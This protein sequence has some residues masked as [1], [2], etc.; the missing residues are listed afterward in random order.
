[1]NRIKSVE[2][3]FSI[4]VFLTP[5]QCTLWAQSTAPV[6]KRI[7]I[8]SLCAIAFWALLTFPFSVAKA[9]INNELEQIKA[10]DDPEVPAFPGAKGFGAVATGGRGGEVYI[11][12][13]LNNSGAGSFR[14]AVEASGPRTIVFAVSGTIELQSSLILRDGNVTIAGQTAPGDGICIKNY[15]FRLGG[16]DNVII[17]YISSRPGIDK[18]SADDAITGGGSNIIID[19]C[20]FS[21]AMDEVASLYAN[22]MLTMQWCIVSESLWKSKHPQG[23]HGMGGIWGGQSVSFHHNL[24]AHNNNRNPR[25]CGSRYT[26]RADL[27]LVDYRN[28][29]IYNWGNNSAYGG[30]GGK[31]NLVNNYYKFGPGTVSSRKKRIIAP[32]A[33]DGSN[34]QAKGVWG[35]F[36]ISGNFVNGFPDVTEDNWL[37]VEEVPDSIIP[38]IKSLTPFAVKEITM[39]SPEDAY[40]DVIDHAGASFPKRDPVDSRISEETRTGTAT[41]A[42]NSSLP[43]IINDPTDVGS[44][45]LLLSAPAPLDTDKDGMPDEWEDENGLNKNDP[46]D[47]KIIAADGYS[48][49]EHY[50]NGLVTDFK[51]LLRPMNLELTVDDKTVSL[52]WTDLSDNESGFILERSA[53]NGANFTQIAELDANTVSYTDNSIEEYGKYQYRIKAINTEMETSFTDPVI[54]EVS[55]PNPP[56]YTLTINQTGSGIVTTSPGGTFFLKGTKVYV[57]AHPAQNWKFE[58][59]SGDISG[60]EANTSII[61]DGDKSVTANFVNVTSVSL[62]DI[63]DRLVIYPNP[64]RERI[65]IKLYLE[66]SAEVVISLLNMQGK[67]LSRS[68]NASAKLGENIFSIGTLGL[69]SQP[70]LLRVTVDGYTINRITMV[71]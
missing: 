20:S 71:E 16:Q 2:S 48:N 23:P 46:A 35:D 10:Y 12:T 21:W 38:L 62:A 18:R 53:D 47:G 58:S 69:S 54:A 4:I 19:H 49:L 36:Y 33:D 31:H 57:I 3:P 26:N 64:A 25:F 30:E 28:N 42:P 51:H 14:E 52:S 17:R 15:P 56:Q 1:M 45:P 50:L 44:Y 6:L 66:K 70:Y 9:S 68:V 40:N 65:N 39:Q 34:A 22:Q 60:G 67:E 41:Y 29:V 63:N 37:G 61:M 11:V 43:G 32:R 8:L 55:D 7:C 13:N 27:E 59:W 24:F 5:C